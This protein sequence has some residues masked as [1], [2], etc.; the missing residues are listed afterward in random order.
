MEVRFT[1]RRR[2]TFA[3]ARLDECAGADGM[4]FFSEKKL[5]F[6]GE[7]SARDF[8]LLLLVFLFPPPLLASN[9]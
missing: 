9:P 1:I 8:A 3:G 6:L 5:L 4:L 2:A 7:K